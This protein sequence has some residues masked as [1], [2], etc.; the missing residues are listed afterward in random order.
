MDTAPEIPTLPIPVDDPGNG[1]EW[2]LLAQTVS[3]HTPFRLSAKTGLS[4]RS[5]S[6]SRL[7]GRGKA[8]P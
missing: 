1:I 8:T 5:I 6:A 3:K 7:L 2:L 4:E